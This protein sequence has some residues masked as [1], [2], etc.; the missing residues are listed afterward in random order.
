MSAH[1]G[2]AT[3]PESVCPLLN[4]MK[5]PEATIKTADGAAFELMPA[6][7]KRPAVLVFYRGG[8]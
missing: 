8:W 3:S 1:D 6:I 7:Q 2:V 4:G 5:I